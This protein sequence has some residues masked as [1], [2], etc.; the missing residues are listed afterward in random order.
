MNN[1]LVHHGILGMKWGIRRYQP[2]P[3]GYSGNG[4]EVGQA[5]KLARQQDRVQKN[6]QQR[7]QKIAIQESTQ[8]QKE[9]LAKRK[10]A[11]NKEQV[12]K[13]GTATELLDYIGE[14]TTAE[15]ENAVRRIEAVSKLQ[16]ASKKEAEAGWNKINNLSSKLKDV[17]N[18]VKTGFETKE[19][20]NKLYKELNKVVESARQR[21]V[22]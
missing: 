17:N 5:S 16:A 13:T 6:S 14:L 7:L 18:W 19:T 21:N 10:K 11:E 4:R 12:L 15:L 1:Y 20:V 9:E 8:K 3:K 2:Y 22:N